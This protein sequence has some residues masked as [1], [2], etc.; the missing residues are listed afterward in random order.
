MD[1]VELIISRIRR[2]TENQDFGDNYGISQNECIGYLN[3]AQDRVYSE[4]IKKHPNLFIKE[5][6]QSVTAGTESYDLPTDIYLRKVNLLEFS[7]STSVTDFYRLDQAQSAERVSYPIGS[8]RYYIG[9]NKSVLL[10][11][12]PNVNGSLRISYVK[13]LPKLDIRRGQILSLVQVGDD[14]TSITLDPAQTLDRDALLDKGWMCVVG[15]DGELKAKEIEITDISTTTGLVTMSTKTLAADEL[16]EVGDYVV[17]GSYATNKSELDDIT[18]RYLSS[19]LRWE[20]LDRDS[21][22]SGS[23]S[24][25]DKA[26]EMLSDIV[27]SFADMGDDTLYP[28]VLDAQYFLGT[29]WD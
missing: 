12:T 11:P 23:A 25:N 8:P 27:D 7:T 16:I 19:H 4:I 28:P 21:N 3:D 18:E 22:S 2:E 5:E 6:T 15:K 14:V 9:R 20:M 1:R 17:A 26:R 24:Q 10:V 13:A 29:G